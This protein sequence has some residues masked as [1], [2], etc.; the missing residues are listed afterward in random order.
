MRFCLLKVQQE[1]PAKKTRLHCDVD[2]NLI[3]STTPDS[4]TPRRTIARRGSLNG[5]EW[6]SIREN[7]DFLVFVSLVSVNALIF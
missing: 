1:S 3:S 7:D 2:N 6:H 4:N 5:R